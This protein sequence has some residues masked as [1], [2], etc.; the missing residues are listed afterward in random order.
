MSPTRGTTAGDLAARAARRVERARAAGKPRPAR[1]GRLT[2]L[3]P[4]PR[5]PARAAAVL[6]ELP[7]E[8]VRPR[9]AV[10][11]HD[12]IRHDDEPHAEVGGARAEVPVLRGGRREALVEAAEGGEPVAVQGQVRAGEEGLRL[13]VVEGVQDRV[14]GRR[15]GV[16]RVR[17]HHRAA[18]QR[19]RISLQRLGESRGPTGRRLAVVVHEGEQPARRAGGS[20]VARP[21]GPV[22]SAW[23]TRTSS[24]GGAAALTAAGAGS[25]PS[26]D[27]TTASPPGTGRCAASAARQR[28]SGSLR[29]QAGTTTVMPAPGVPISSSVA[30]PMVPLKFGLVGCGRIAEHGWLPALRSAAA[31]GTAELV[32]IAEPDARAARP[33]PGPRGSMAAGPSPIGAT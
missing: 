6:G 20:A 32:S 3:R 23:T 4:Q 13:A 16:A 10:V 31:A 25:A 7:P 15:G 24:P 8:V 12:R 33:P 9:R 27:T 30:R 18:R 26:I 21:A 29:P 22:R 2:G 19:A 11:A 28:Y 17:V 14:R 1:I 5:E